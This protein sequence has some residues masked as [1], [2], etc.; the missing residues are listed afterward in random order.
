MTKKYIE[1]IDGLKII[2]LISSDQLKIRTKI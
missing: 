2:R 1:M